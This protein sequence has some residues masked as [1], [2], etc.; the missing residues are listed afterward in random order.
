MFISVVAM[1]RYHY[2]Y[3]FP[4]GKLGKNGKRAFFAKKR[5]I[6]QGAPECDCAPSLFGTLHAPDLFKYKKQQKRFRK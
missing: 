1:I 3:V 2:L 4:S 5:H 6:G